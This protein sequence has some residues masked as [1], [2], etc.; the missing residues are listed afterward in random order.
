MFR[1]QTDPRHPCRALL[2]SSDLACRDRPKGRNPALNVK[3]SYFSKIFGDL[4]PQTSQHSEREPRY[5]Q[6]FGEIL[7]ASPTCPVSAGAFKQALSN[8]WRQ[9]TKKTQKKS[10]FL[11]PG[12][13]G[14]FREV[15]QKKIQ[16]LR[17]PIN[18]TPREFASG[19]T[20]IP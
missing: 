5:L 14:V 11:F 6:I 16:I 8:L 19:R 9:K 18:S 13:S 12:G 7:R 15:G 20:N 2:T 17:K 4:A 3:S 1:L 10:E